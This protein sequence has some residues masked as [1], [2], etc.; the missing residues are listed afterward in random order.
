[1][2]LADDT[3]M[4]TSTGMS[5][6]FSNTSSV[7]ISGDDITPGRTCRSSRSTRFSCPR[8]GIVGMM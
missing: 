5:I 2:P 1:M 6:G 8:T 7:S 3:V 4:R